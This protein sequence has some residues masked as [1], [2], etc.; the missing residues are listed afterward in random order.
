MDNT[1]VATGDS[2]LSQHVTSKFHSNMSP[3]SHPDDLQPRRHQRLI[4]HLLVRVAHGGLISFHFDLTLD[5]STSQTA[6]F[7][8]LRITYMAEAILRL[9]ALGGHEEGCVLG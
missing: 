9:L 7:T 5:M 4:V 8:A 2:I 1:V 6:F 3:S